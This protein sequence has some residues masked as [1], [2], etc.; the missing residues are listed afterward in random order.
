[1]GKFKILNWHNFYSD[2]YLKSYQKFI[3]NIDKVRQ[4][5]NI[6]SDN[7]KQKFWRYYY[8]FVIKSIKLFGYLLCNNGVMTTQE[9]NMV[10]TMLNFELL[11]DGEKFFELY[12][13]LK[14][15]KKQNFLSVDPAIIKYLDESYVVLFEELNTFFASRLKNEANYEF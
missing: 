9:K 2:N 10:L 11:S 3:K 7:E 4:C 8:N 1:M 6:Y 13:T 5:Y 14:S 15:M 12:S